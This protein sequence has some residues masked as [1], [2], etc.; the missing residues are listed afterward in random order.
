MKFPILFR[1]RA[2]ARCQKEGCWERPPERIPYLKLDF[3]NRPQG[4]PDAVLPPSANPELQPHT[5]PV[6]RI[7]G[8]HPHLPQITILPFS[9]FQKNQKS[10]LGIF[11]GKI[12]IALY[13]WE[14]C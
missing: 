11:L 5:L 12:R 10:E 7:P 14:T 13:F 3:V 9:T 2:A 6:K 4:G 1:M 8:G